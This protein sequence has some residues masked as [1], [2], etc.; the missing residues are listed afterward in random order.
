MCFSDSINKKM[1]SNKRWIVPLIIQRSTLVQPT[2]YNTYPSYYSPHFFCVSRSLTLS[3]ND[4][5]LCVFQ[6]CCPLFELHN[7][8][9]TAAST[10]HLLAFQFWNDN[11]EVIRIFRHTNLEKL[12][13]HPAMSHRVVVIPRHLADEDL[14][15]WTAVLGT[16][17]DDDDDDDDDDNADDNVNLYPNNQ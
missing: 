6:K 15:G 9:C 7:L 12:L 8:N 1:V 2:N 14:I 11:S 3:Y 5:V 4:T 13:T 16:S 17:D 10:H